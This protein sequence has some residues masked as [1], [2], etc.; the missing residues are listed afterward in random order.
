MIA[1]DAALVAVLVVLIRLR[2]RARQEATGATLTAEEVAVGHPMLDPTWTPQRGYSHAD[3][4]L[5][6]LREAEARR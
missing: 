4:L 1:V 6:I 2:L 3:R 5:A